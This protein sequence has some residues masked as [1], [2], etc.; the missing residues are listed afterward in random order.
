MLKKDFLDTFIGRIFGKYRLKQNIII[1]FFSFFIYYFTFFLNRDTEPVSSPKQ[2]QEKAINKNDDLINRVNIVAKR[3]QPLE[4][5]LKN[6]I[7]SFEF[8]QYF[9]QF[10]NDVNNLR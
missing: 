6:L 10:I 4:N 8:N 1:F 9:D 3:I 2:E 7:N 5:N